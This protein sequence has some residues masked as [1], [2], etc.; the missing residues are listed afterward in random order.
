MEEFG[1]FKR[2]NFIL[3]A[4][5]C[6]TVMIC[7][8]LLPLVISIHSEGFSEGLKNCLDVFSWVILWRPIYDLLF[9][10]NPYLKDILLLHKLATAE[11]IIIDSK[12]SAEP[13]QPLKYNK[14]NGM[15]LSESLTL[16]S[17]LSNRI[18]DICLTL[19]FH[20]PRLVQLSG[21]PGG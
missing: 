16:E 19:A 3:L 12:K 13:D 4:I 7:Q 11:V 8:S 17:L 18:H 2:R 21:K 5:S 6:A 10:W 9:E 1:K 15:E 20:L 14:R